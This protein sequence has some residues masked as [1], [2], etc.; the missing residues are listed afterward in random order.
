ME[1]KSNVQRRR[2]NRIKQLHSRAAEQTE[3]AGYRGIIEME[4][5]RTGDNLDHGG[6]PEIAWRQ[7]E[8]QLL[9]WYSRLDGHTD[10]LEAYHT[11]RNPDK[12]RRGR[13]FLVKLTIAAVLF[14][15]IYTIYRLETPWAEGARSYIVAVLTENMDFSSAAAWYD[16]TFSGG[17]SLL[18][19]FRDKQ[20]TAKVERVTVDNPFIQPVLGAVMKPYDDKSGGIWIAT[21]PNAEAV[22]MDEGR[23]EFAG[24]RQD[25]GHT[26]VIRHADGFRAEYGGLQPTDW[27]LGDWV[28]AGER[29]GMIAANEA[30]NGA[31]YLAIIKDQHYINPLDVVSID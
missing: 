17:P 2:Q 3:E 26:I 20:E 1:L 12:T 4:E 6:D 13:S 10:M 19:A 8:Q 16:R 14:T 21:N 24:D 9:Q 25:T 18:P 27:S 31:F 28:Q 22:A 29:V 11:P 7:K 30:G 15:S 5:S 23:I